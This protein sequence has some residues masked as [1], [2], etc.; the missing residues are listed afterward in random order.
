MRQSHARAD[1]GCR[2][3][4]GIRSLIVTLFDRNCSTGLLRC[5]T[6]HYLSVTIADSSLLSHGLARYMRMCQCPPSHFAAV[7]AQFQGEFLDSSVDIDVH[8]VAL[9]RSCVHGLIVSDDITGRLAVSAGGDYVRLA[10]VWNYVR[11][12]DEAT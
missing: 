1:S 8:R 4:R 6:L 2:R 3:L 9:L 5:S 10:G 12:E 7:R 11:R